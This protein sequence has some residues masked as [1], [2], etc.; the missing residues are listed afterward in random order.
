MPNAIWVA[1]VVLASGCVPV[2]AQTQPRDPARDRPSEY[3]TCPRDHLTSYTGLVTG[4]RRENG[5]TSLTIRTDWDTT[6]RVE[7]KHPG[8][9]D[10]SRW[11]LLR[12]RPFT[13]DDWKEIEV[14]RGR[15]KPKMRASAWVCDD[16]TNAILDW[17]RPRE[18]L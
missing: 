16:G 14:E 1:A 2:L 17:D 6:E 8:T 9:D 3:I 10:P 5:R 15:L 7:L 4:Y 18:K 13:P 12:G 11:F